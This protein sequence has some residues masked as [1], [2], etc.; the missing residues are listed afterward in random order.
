MTYLGPVSTLQYVQI[1]NFTQMSFFET[2][3][4]I[5]LQANSQLSAVFQENTP[6]HG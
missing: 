3:S 1:E 4:A 2:A 6:A 5:F